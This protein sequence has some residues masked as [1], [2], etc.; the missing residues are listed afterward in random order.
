MC[1]GGA[2]F[3]AFASLL[4]ARRRLAAGARAKGGCRISLQAFSPAGGNRSTCPSLAVRNARRD[5]LSW[6]VSRLSSTAGPEDDG[7]SLPRK[8]AVFD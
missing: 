6:V 7:A 1:Q 5:R 8:S 2:G 4:D 3:G